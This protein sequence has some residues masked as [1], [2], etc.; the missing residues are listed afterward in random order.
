MLDKRAG[1]AFHTLSIVSSDFRHSGTSLCG[2]M[3]EEVTTL[4]SEDMNPATAGQNLLTYRSEKKKDA[5][6]SVFEQG[7]PDNVKCKH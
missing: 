1:G 7:S 4:P 5:L 3:N 2:V 6:V